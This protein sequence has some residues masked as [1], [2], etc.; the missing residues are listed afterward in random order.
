[1]SETV[2]V[3]AGGVLVLTDVSVAT[4]VLPTVVVVVGSVGVV[5]LVTVVGVEVIGVLVV[6]E[7]EETVGADGVVVSVLTVGE[8]LVVPRSTSPSANAGATLNK[9]TETIVT[10]E[11]NTFIFFMMVLDQ[12]V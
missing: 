10:S 3:V 12:D 6:E 4:V 1:M 9:R 5:V 11:P 7:L 2:T 8:E